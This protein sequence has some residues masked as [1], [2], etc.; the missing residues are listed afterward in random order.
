ML[1][2][3]GALVTDHPRV[4]DPVAE[5]VGGPIQIWCVLDPDTASPRTE[6]L[7]EAAALAATLRGTVT[8]V[9]AHPPASPL[10]PAGA[11]RVLVV[12]SVHASDAAERLA[13]LVG[14]ER[15]RILLV[16]G[17]I[18]GR[19]ITSKVAA[20]HG[21]GLIGDGIEIEAS[22]DGAL[23]VWK[24]AFGGRLLAAITS[25]SDIQVA[26]GATRRPAPS[27]RAPPSRRAGG[28]AGR[29]D[30]GP[31]CRTR[32]VIDLRHGSPA[33]LAGAD[34]V[35]GVGQGVDPDDYRLLE[36]LRELLGAVLGA[37]RKVTDRGWMPRGRQIGITGISISPRLYVAI[38]A[39]GRF[40]PRLGLPGRHSRPRDQQ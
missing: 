27:R 5:H 21:L 10:G 33:E 2:Q 22:V 6:L 37:T 9:V 30:R 3:R 4:L 17:T 36:P 1:R 39:S 19:V 13:L 26:H 34:V 24:P 8:A 11:D 40:Q 23:T 38:G 25:T 31:N 12:P 35:I 15:P 18:A 7:G 14:I 32:V 29:P 20:R 28:D 16:E